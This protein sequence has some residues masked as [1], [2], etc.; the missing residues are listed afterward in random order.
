MTKKTQTLK[1][2]MAS[3]IIGTMGYLITT[4]TIDSI[5]QANKIEKLSLA[6]EGHSGV[7]FDTNLHKASSVLSDPTYSSIYNEYHNQLERN[8]KSASGKYSIENITSNIHSNAISPIFGGGFFVGDDSGRISIINENGE[9]EFVLDGNGD[10]IHYF[11]KDE[12]SGE[13]IQI[14]GIKFIGNNKYVVIGGSDTIRARGGAYTIIDSQGN[15]APQFLDP[16]NDPESEK[17]NYRQLPTMWSVKPS[18]IGKSISFVERHETGNGFIMG[19]NGRAEFWYLDN[20]GNILNDGNPF[21]WG[22]DTTNDVHSNAIHV[23]GNHYAYVLKNTLQLFEITSTHIAFKGSMQV[24]DSTNPIN[25]IINMGQNEQDTN[26]ITLLLSS[27]GSVSNVGGQFAKVSFR[28]DNNSFASTAPIK[29]SLIPYA[30]NSR[31]HITATEQGWSF[32]YNN[33]G[34][35]RKVNNNLDFEMRSSNLDKTSSSTI[36]KESWWWNINLKDSGIAENLKKILPDGRGGFFAFFDNHGIIRIDTNGQQVEYRSSVRGNNDYSAYQSYLST[37]WA[38]KALFSTYNGSGNRIFQIIPWK[39]KYYALS[40]PYSNNVARLIRLNANMSVDSSFSERSISLSP[41]E[42]I[43]KAILQNYIVTTEESYDEEVLFI[44]TSYGNIIALN[45]DGRNLTSDIDGLKNIEVTADDVGGTAENNRSITGIQVSKTDNVQKIY[46]SRQNLIYKLSEGEVSVMTTGKHNMSGIIDMVSVGANDAFNGHNVQFLVVTNDGSMFAFGDKNEFIDENVIDRWYRFGAAT[47]SSSNPW[48]NATTYKDATRV[49]DAGDG[50][51]FVYGLSGKITKVN[52]QYSG[53]SGIR[54]SKDPNFITAGE[55]TAARLLQTNGNGEANEQITSMANM[56]DGSYLIG[57]TKGRVTRINKDGSFVKG[58]EI[59]SSNPGKYLFAAPGGGMTNDAVISQI[60]SDGQ[61]FYFAVEAKLGRITLINPDANAVLQN[62]ETKSETLA[63]WHKG[64]VRHQIDLTNYFS[65]LWF[66]GPEGGATMNHVLLPRGL[67]LEYSLNDYEWFDNVYSMNI[68][69]GDTVTIRAI[70]DTSVSTPYIFKDQLTKTTL[71]IKGLKEVIDG[72]VIFAPANVAIEGDSDDLSIWFNYKHPHAGIDDDGYNF[73][74]RNVRVEYFHN[75]VWST[76]IPTNINNGDSIQM[77]VSPNSNF[78][79][80]KYQIVNDTQTIIVNSL[81]KKIIDASAYISTFV[82]AGSVRNAS[83][84]TATSDEI[85]IENTKFQFSFVGGSFDNNWFDD[86]PTDLL[87]NGQMLY[88]RLVPNSNFNDSAYVLSNT[89]RILFVNSLEKNKIDLSSVLNSVE[90]TGAPA[91]GTQTLTMDQI[92]DLAVLPGISGF[93]SVDG[94]WK[95]RIEGSNVIYDAFPSNMLHNGSKLTMWFELD[96]NNNELVRNNELSYFQKTITVTGLVYSSIDMSD[97]WKGTKFIGQAINNGAAFYENNNMLPPY[98]IR[99]EFSY[100]NVTWVPITQSTA[101]TLENGR[102]IYLRGVAEIGFP[103]DT[104]VLSN[105]THQ[106]IPKNL[107][108]LELDVESK[109]QAIQITGQVKQLIFES[110]DPSFERT[111][112]YYSMLKNPDRGNP[113]HWKLAPMSTSDKLSILNGSIIHYTYYQDNTFDNNNYSITNNRVFKYVVNNLIKGQIDAT[114]YLTDDSFTFTKNAQGHSIVTTK[115]I[116]KEIGGMYQ[117]SIDG[118]LS[119]M[120]ELPIN[121]SNGDDISVQIIPSIADGFNDESFELH[122]TVRTSLIIQGMPRTAVNVGDIILSLSIDTT[123]TAHSGKFD[124]SIDPLLPMAADLKYEFAFDNTINSNTVWYS[125]ED[126]G[127]SSLDPTHP[128]NKLYNGQNYYVRVGHKVTFDDLNFELVNNISDRKVVSGLLKMQINPSTYYPSFSISGTVNSPTYNKP[129]LDS[130][131]TNIVEW[132]YTL[133]SQQTSGTWTNNEI[134]GIKNGDTLYARIYPKSN[135]DALNLELD[136]ITVPFATVIVANLAKANVS[137]SVVL[138]TIRF[139]GDST[140]ASIQYVNILEDTQL[141]YSTSL[142]GT[143]T[144]INN[145]D[146]INGL[147]N[148]DVLYFKLEADQSSDLWQYNFNLVNSQISYL[149]SGLNLAIFDMSWF[150]NNSASYTFHGENNT[151]SKGIAHSGQMTINT[152]NIKNSPGYNLVNS[153]ENYIEFHYKFE[154]SSSFT[155]YKTNTKPSKLFNG[156]KIIMYGS[157]TSAGQKLFALSDNYVEIQI[158]DTQFDKATYSATTISN[159]LKISGYAGNAIYTLPTSIKNIDLSYSLNSNVLPGDFEEL[160]SKEIWNGDV[161]N[162]RIA[163]SLIF[164]DLNYKLIE[165]DGDTTEVTEF[166]RSITISTLL[167]NSLSVTNVLN[168]IE[169]ERDASGNTVA[170]ISQ[171]LE[172]FVTNNNIE[173]LYG[174]GNSLPADASFVQTLPT[175]LVNRDR[176]WIKVVHGTNFD[177]ANFAISSTFTNNLK[178][179]LVTG[180]EKVDVDFDAFLNSVSFSG[181]AFQGTLSF[182][183][184]TLPTPGINISLYFMVGYSINNG[185]VSYSIPTTLNNNDTLKINIIP[186]STFNNTALINENYT[187]INTERFF[188]SID[189]LSKINVDPSIL[190]SGHSLVGTSFS[191]PS[192]SPSLSTIKNYDRFQFMYSMTDSYGSYSEIMPELSNGETLYVQVELID[193]NDYNNFDLSGTTHSFVVNTLTKKKIDLSSYWSS[194]R[195]S[196]FTGAGEVH[197]EQFEDY[198]TLEYQL[199]D[200]IGSATWISYESNKPNNLK[201]GDK[202]HFRA[203]S[204]MNFDTKNFELS[205]TEIFHT[206]SGLSPI[207]IDL[208]NVT[209]LFGITGEVNAAV[210]QKPSNINSLLPA[211]TIVKYQI[212]SNPVPTNAW[213]DTFNGNGVKNDHFLHI[214]ID[215]TAGFDNTNYSLANDIYTLSIKGL[216]K[217]NINIRDF[218]SK[219][220]IQGGLNNATINY[221]G[222]STEDN[223]LLLQVK[224]Q[225]AL[226]PTNSNSKLEWINWTSGQSLNTVVANGQQIQFRFLN[227]ISYDPN[228]YNILFQEVGTKVITGL[229]YLYDFNSFWSAFR[230]SGGVQNAKLTHNSLDSNFKLQFRLSSYNEGMPFEDWEIAK[231]FIK[232]N[233]TIKVKIVNADGTEVGLVNNVWPLSN[234]NEGYKITGLE[235]WQINAQWYVD[236]FNA[237]GT[238]LSPNAKHFEIVEGDALYSIKEHITYKYQVTRTNNVSDW[239][240]TLPNNLWNGDKVRVKMEINPIA[241][242]ANNYEFINTISTN[243]HTISKMSSLSIL[244]SDWFSTNKFTVIKN[245]DGDIVL[246]I[247]DLDLDYLQVLYSLNDEEYSNEIPIIADLSGTVYLKLAL[248]SNAARRYSIPDSDDSFSI[249]YSFETP[250]NDKPVVN[251][252]LVIAIIIGLN[253]STIVLASGLIALIKKRNNLSK[254]EDKLEHDENVHYLEYY[255]DYYNDENK[256]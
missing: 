126:P 177:S 251:K 18:Q 65:Q 236:E 78:D 154:S 193:Q 71:T 17:R 20:D 143:Y 243:A 128:L 68:F 15:V 203:R 135:F 229:N 148:S 47:N 76:D 11:G 72:A 187:F 104:H 199:N 216:T 16:S 52:Y 91:P 95:F 40:N 42:K 132:Q 94:M 105:A 182:T 249:K 115:N 198:L 63:R 69:N 100:D 129:V 120:D 32:V 26:L 173:I 74:Q 93:T 226:I 228:N 230:I 101:L 61:G 97:Y 240:E 37:R 196:G 131:I 103:L 183:T 113:S 141:S 164:D 139:N 33:E 255:K 75:G 160:P 233:D 167:K 27:N 213:V 31:E 56:P 144:P 153:I 171:I 80:E 7:F 12:V 239:L 195:F 157:L 138:D 170:N 133:D 64:Y 79:Y 114:D 225:Y 24:F 124:S 9:G 82:V 99:I 4:G 214:K 146:I 109:F 25:E 21:V 19:Q 125:Y 169:I 163:K 201:N 244:Q 250:I 238:Y 180:L 62:S 36:G 181:N 188:S 202:I 117:Y 96:Q 130:L 92:E 174:V 46:F 184:S 206:L 106:Y 256:S 55:K 194:I 245:K 186:N 122:N 59:D 58:F 176:L 219:I 48:D 118:G 73:G 116:G 28:K 107:A 155:T 215:K 246:Q 165:K 200:S 152:Q 234:T 66:A 208:S 149:V 14:T 211:N 212:S 158:S 235:K 247:P 38:D 51:L 237:E 218:E 151:S 224:S 191:Q 159:Q 34:Q 83:F 223:Q 50:S 242:D 127:Y 23:F 88:I 13:G 192:W 102:L 8:P 142:S 90:I 190:L 156:Q 35:L 81:G 53:M 185:P 49:H 77:K 231:S 39:N 41:N 136:L 60:I 85:A 111:K 84:T 147:S 123:T 189:V 205:N 220:I 108:K 179:F 86:F 2:L 150:L 162:I 227:S 161:L 232:N 87:H 44:G 119:W 98:P 121:L 197:F 168:G 145:G 57:M 204:N 1:L 29:K 222:L 134:K 207:Y 22:G 241:Y 210:L 30:S 254:L 3:T 172:N 5:L 110:Y 70:Q 217:V 10:P 175:N 209:K 248:T 6:S 45:Y 252:P 221:N 54:G 137:A 166:V 140:N 253:I 89:E 112:L 67:K 43:T 178:T